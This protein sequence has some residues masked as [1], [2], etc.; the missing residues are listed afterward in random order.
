MSDSV[1]LVASCWLYDARRPAWHLRLDTP[2]WFA[3]LNEPTTHSF[4]YPLFDP[5][6]G[7]S[8]GRLTVRKERR[9]R[10]G[11]YW[12]AYRRAH[13]QVH[14][15]YLGRTECLTQARLEAVAATVCTR[16]AGPQPS[17]GAQRT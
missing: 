3:W 10:G 5:R 8:V 14:K 15:V 17:T 13:G 16:A 9:Q 6:L 2:A 12:T 11:T 1:P 7:Y 4:A